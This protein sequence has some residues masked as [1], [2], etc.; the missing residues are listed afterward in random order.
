MAVATGVRWVAASALAGAL[1]VAQAADYAG[2]QVDLAVMTCEGSTQAVVIDATQMWCDGRWVLGTG[3]VQSRQGL[4]IH[5]RLGVAMQQ[6]HIVAPAV[7]IDS[8]GDVN[9]G[10]DTHVDAG[11]VT[12]TTPDGQPGGV[13]SVAPGVTLAGHDSG[14][15]VRMFQGDV[16]L[17]PEVKPIV[18]AIAVDPVVRGGDIVLRADEG[19]VQAS[20]PAASVPA[21]ASGAASSVASATPAAVGNDGVANTA[22]N[23]GGAGAL[24]AS[25]LLWLAI[26]VASLWLWPRRAHQP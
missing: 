20:G 21:A 3:A 1:S 10:A 17:S 18:T 5:G 13:L 9:L 26:G 7:R 6:V 4:L 11:Q 8:A 15:A 22:D 12:I 16:S 23:Q 19:V 14:L 25:A 24:D 2:L